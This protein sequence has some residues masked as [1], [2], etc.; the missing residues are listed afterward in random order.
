M[1]RKAG[2]V[3]ETW[4]YT[5]DGQ[6]IEVPVRVIQRGGR[7]V[8]AVDIDEP[9][10]QAYHVDSH[11][12]KKNAWAAIRLAVSIAWR[13]VYVLEVEGGPVD[14]H[15]V[16]PGKAYELKFGYNH[17]EVGTTPDGAHVHRQPVN[18]SYPDFTRN[19]HRGL[20]SD[21][22]AIVDATPEN[23]A[24]I[25]AVLASM[26][27]LHEM[28]ADLM[29]PEKAQQTLANVRLLGLPAPAKARPDED[30]E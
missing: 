7:L 27:R 30:E 24:R 9:H 11:E 10:V 29:S 1:A 3:V 28:M 4:W 17:M 25:M 14:T 18:K 6:R 16:G 2:K 20:P 22:S 26:R 13:E 12:L 23:K 19:V 5:E 15:S 21:S 8:F